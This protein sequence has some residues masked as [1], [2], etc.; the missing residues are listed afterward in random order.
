MVIK[1]S[2]YTQPEAVDSFLGQL[3][4]KPTKIIIYPN[5]KYRMYE[6]GDIIFVAA[7]K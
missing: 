4:G 5:P 2:A 7:P 3:T 6:D 1:Q